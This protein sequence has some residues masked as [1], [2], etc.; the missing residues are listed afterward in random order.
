MT[1]KPLMARA[2]AVW[3]VD[4][5]TL[6]FKQIGDFCG[7]HEL[8]V[9]GIADGIRGSGVIES[10]TCVETSLRR[11]SSVITPPSRAFFSLAFWIAESSSD[12]RQRPSATGSTGSMLPMFQCVRSRIAWIVGLVVPTSLEI[13]PSDNS[14]WNLTSQ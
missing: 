9:Q 7:L 5:T 3:L 14:G 8:E 13:W 4:N 10:E 12:W 1:D 6:N 2:T 11:S